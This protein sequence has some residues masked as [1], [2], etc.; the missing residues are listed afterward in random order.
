M[1]EGFCCSARQKTAGILFVL[2][3]F[4]TRQG[5]NRPR[6]AASNACAYRS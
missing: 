2:Q 6:R 5:G 4:L 1:E 3:E